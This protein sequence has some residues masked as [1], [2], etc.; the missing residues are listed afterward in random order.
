LGAGADEFRQ[1]GDGFGAW[2]GQSVSQIV[3][4]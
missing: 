2:D 3:P 1:L 4:E